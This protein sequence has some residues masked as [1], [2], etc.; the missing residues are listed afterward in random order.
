MDYELADIVSDHYRNLKMTNHQYKVLSNIMFCRTKKLGGHKLKCS[1]LKCNHTENLYNSCRDR[2]CP[3]CQG[4]NQIKWKNKKLNELLPVMYNLLTFTIPRAFYELFSYN[5]AECYKVLYDSVK[6]TLSINTFKIGFNLVFH[7]WT[8]QLN[9]HPHIHC[10]I[11]NVKV[12]NDSKNKITSKQLRFDLDK[13]NAKFKRIL[14]KKIMYLYRKQRLTY[15][16][17]SDS[18]IESQL[19]NSNRSI[20]LSKNTDPSTMIDYLGN[21]TSKTAI[22]NKRITKYNGTDITFTYSDRNDSYNLKEKEINAELFLKRFMLHILPARFTR[23]RYY[24]FMA[25][26]CK[27]I[28]DR[29]REHLNEMNHDVS[30]L[31]VIIVQRISLLIRKLLKPIQCPCCAEG[32]MEILYS[33]S[34]G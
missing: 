31:R 17:L 34:G 5:Q 25:N 14:K 8:Q 10:Y 24:G 30:D 19:H 28:L 26:N 15:P 12:Q 6:E 33:F 32:E 21:N 20:H 18:F 27:K 22:N 13:L 2:H 3:K 7:T 16:L 4:S 9:Y 1:N 23:I 11:P 29:I